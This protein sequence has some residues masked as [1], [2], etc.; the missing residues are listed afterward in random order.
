MNYAAHWK[1]TGAMEEGK[2]E[3]VGGIARDGIM[4]SLGF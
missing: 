4:C 2:E 3:T 1:V